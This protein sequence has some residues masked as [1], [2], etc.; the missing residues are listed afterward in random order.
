MTDRAPPVVIGEE[1]LAA[2]V[3][4]LA[5]RLAARVDDTWLA[6]TLLE[7]AGP[8]SFDLQRALARRGRHL[9]S[10]CLWLSSYGEAR[11]SSGEVRVTAPLSRPPAGRPCLIVDDVFDTGRTL[12]FAR[13]HVLELGALEAVCVVLARKPVAAQAALEPDDWALE[14]P[15][16]FLVGYG[17][18]EAGRWR[19]LP[20]IGALD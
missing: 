16:R 8:F 17:M 1:A 15:D 13:R 7:G 12:A 19:S 2:A 6:V 14:A 3:E 5:D 18:D 9:E 4:A 10:A 20:Y 11:V